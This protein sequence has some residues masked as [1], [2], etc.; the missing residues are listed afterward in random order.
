MRVMVCG[1][2]GNLGRTLLHL[3]PHFI[4]LTSQQLDITN[5]T[6]VQQAI[7]HYKPHII[8]NAAAYTDV[9]GSYFHSQIAKA[10]N[11]YGAVNLAKFDIPILH[12]STDYIFAG[13]KIGAYAEDDNPNPL[14]IYGKTKLQAEQLISD[15]NP[16]HVIVRSS[17]LFGALGNNFLTKILRLAQQYKSIKMVSDQVG[18][19]ISYRCLAVALIRLVDIYQQNQHLSWG[20]YHYAGLDAYSRYEFTRLI[21]AKAYELKIISH[22]PQIEPIISIEYKS[23]VKRP[24]N[25]CLDSSLFARIF[26]IDVPELLPNLMRELYALS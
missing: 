12:I 9:D 20:I 16:Q 11:A 19:A 2:N 13:N 7:S 23:E 3:A 17:W 4:G 25:C 5:F 10:V 24:L 18:C 21:C 1:A 22:I 8:I 6:Q 15:M 14:N 26:N